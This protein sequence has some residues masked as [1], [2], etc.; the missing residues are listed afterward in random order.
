MGLSDDR[1]IIE[2]NAS[3]LSKIETLL[4]KCDLPFE[5]CHEHLESFFGIIDDG[6]LVTVGALQLNGAV[7]LLRSIAVPPENRRQG[8]A[9]KMTR[10]LLAVARSKQVRE[11]YLLTETAE[12][13]FARFGFCAVERETVPDNI[14]S[15]RQFETLCPASAQVMRLFL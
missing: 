11:L 6:R 2:L 14:K 4:Q 9:V 12:N 8:L 5:D 13:Y 15:T 10:H 3:H 1:Q 7:A